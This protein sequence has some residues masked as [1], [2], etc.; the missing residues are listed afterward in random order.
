MS[1]ERM[2]HPAVSLLLGCGIDLPAQA[3]RA[4]AMWLAGRQGRPPLLLV[5]L[6]WARD[7]PDVVQ[8]LQGY[9]D[10]LFADY[11]CTPAGWSEAQAARQVLAALNQQLFHMRQTGRSVPQLDAG[12]LLLQGADAQF[13]QAGA[14]GLLRYKG[15]GLHSLAGREGMQLG[16]QAELALVQYSLP[17]SAGEALLLAPQPLL[18]VADLDAFRAGCQTL[19]VESMP[20]L[21]A[22]WL[23]APG[24]AALLLSGA[25]ASLPPA[26]PRE[27]W[28]ALA[29]A[30]TGMRV[31]GWTLLDECPFGPP[32]RLFRARDDSGREALL[33]LAEEA[34]DEVFW[35]REWALRRSPVAS[36]PRV[37]SAHRPRRHAFMLFEPPAAGLR[38]LVD[39]LAAHGPVDGSTLL[40]LLDQAIAAVR[41]LQRRGMQGLWLSPRNILISAGGRLLLLPEHAALLPGVPRQ[42]LPSEAIP[43]APELRG[44]QR[45]DGRADQFALAALAY[46][47]ICGQWPEIARPEGGV[48]SRYVPLATFTTHLPAGWDGVLARALAPQPAARFEALSE[49]RQALQEPLAH[50]P[51]PVRVNLRTQP[52]RLALLGALV[53]QLGFGLWLSLQG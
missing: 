44:P 27:Q 21:L 28:P 45:V 23:K 22:P 19:V 31:D 14:V 12:L 42:P 36:L 16:M 51:A 29:E 52:W 34:A 25:A 35:Q 10:A 11:R 13:L 6:L 9:L 5:A 17:L 18:G 43:L 2:D 30:V 46:W 49:F 7:C 1:I 33:W 37:L 20:A 24:A 39:W 53:I 41:A 4:R 47:L 50:P 38:S 32:G 26:T 3:A 15:G 40:S 48:L 8:R